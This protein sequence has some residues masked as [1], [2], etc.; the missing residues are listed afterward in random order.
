M[1][2][3]YSYYASDVDKLNEFV[4]AFFNRIEFETGDF[5]T[6]FFEKEFYDNLVKRHRRILLKPFKDIYNITKG[7]KQPERTKL[8]KAIRDSNKIEDI[9]LGKMKPTKESEIKG[10]LKSIIV[11]LFKKLYKDVLFGEFFV[12]H[13]GNRRTHYHNFLKYKKNELDWCPSCGIRPMH[14]FTEDITDQYDHYLPK[15]IYPFSSINFKNLV[16]I[17]SDCNSLLVKSNDDILNHT[18]KVIYPFDEKHNPIEISIVIGKNDNDITKIEWAFNYTCSIGKDDELEAWKQIYKI[19]DRHKKHCQGSSK[20]WY[21]HYWTYFNDADS[22]ADEPNEL[23]R[24]NAYLRTRK[25]N[26]FEHKCLATLIS[27]KR[28][29]KESLDSSRY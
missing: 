28:A 22:I 24:K 21:A 17:C 27:D 2:N 16:P 19:E 13:Y 11:S 15:D 1:I 4:L 14:R 12:P 8:C 26:P 10:P 25:N 7:W 20:S 6:T 9:C 29:F 5:A 23:K 18:G 3:T